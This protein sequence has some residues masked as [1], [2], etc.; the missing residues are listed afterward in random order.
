M[1]HKLLL[2]LSLSHTHTHTRRVR[3][4]PPAPLDG[5][6]PVYRKLHCGGR[7]FFIHS[8][9]PRE[10]L[11]LPDS[12]TPLAVVDVHHCH[13]TDSTN[14]KTTMCWWPQPPPGRQSTQWR[15]TKGERDHHSPTRTRTHK[16][17]TDHT[18]WIARKRKHSNAG[19]SQQA[20]VPKPAHTFVPLYCRP[21]AASLSAVLAAPPLRSLAAVPGGGVMHCWL[22]VWAQVPLVCLLVPAE[23]NTFAASCGA[24]LCWI[25][26]SGVRSM[27]FPVP[28]THTHTYTAYL[29]CRHNDH[30][31][32]GQG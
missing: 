27:L 10:H 7:R 12:P 25:G 15:E 13:S 20:Q 22:G 11:F 18:S 3:P 31:P 4:D 2:L 8:H 9:S 5:G 29:H 26:N 30:P 24:G 23:A 32:C 1:A 17:R 19:A 6:L 16:K 14:M 21:T 28:L